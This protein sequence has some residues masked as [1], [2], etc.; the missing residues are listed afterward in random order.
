MPTSGLAICRSM[1]NMPDSSSIGAHG[2]KSLQ[3]EKQS[4]YQLAI[5]TQVDQQI[6]WPVPDSA[7]HNIERRSRRM[8]GMLKRNG[9]LTW[10]QLGSHSNR[11]RERHLRHTGKGG[12]LR[13]GGSDMEGAAG[14][15]GRGCS[16]AGREGA[17]QRAP[18]RAGHPEVLDELQDPPA[19]EVRY[20][21]QAL[22]ACI[23]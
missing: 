18:R 21:H 17:R 9:P 8:Q 13:H 6:P 11:Q 19:L 16:A 5:F 7:I 3:D 22:H 20:A 12:R 15:H 2:I 23:H 14:I 1:C 4:M 10:A